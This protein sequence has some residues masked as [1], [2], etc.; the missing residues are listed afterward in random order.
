MLQVWQ[1][2][3]TALDDPCLREPALG[4]ADTT[5][6]LQTVWRVVATLA[7]TPTLPIRAAG[8][9]PV[10]TCCEE[11]YAAVTVP[12]TGTMTASTGGPSADCGCEPVAAA[13]YQGIENQLYRVEIHQGGDETEATFKWSR[14]NG[15]VVAAVTGISGSTV[16]VSSLGP[17]A[18]LGFQA[19][20]WVELTD[21]TYQFGRPPN[22]PG[23]LYQIKSVQP[24]DLS[25]TL[26]G[27]VTPVDT[28]RNA[29]LRR[30]DQ[31]GPTAAADGIP[32]SA[33]SSIA[34]ENGIEVSFRPAATPAA[35][36]GRSRPGPRPGRSTG[37]PAAATGTRSSPR[38]RF[39]F[40]A[41]RSP[42]CTGHRPRRCHGAA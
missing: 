33:G 37:L 9:P 10:P 20:Q 19:G 28:T 5:A 32:L 38:S 30:W 15:S 41:R 36:T 4:Q 7:R 13:G 21:D 12:S 3:V 27:S 14:E 29:R 35:T 40:T 2:L 42:A 16:Q 23:T 39:R 24:S 6:R 26:V 8:A 11:M 34:L 22:Q 18:N 17:D 1:R 31:A 25:V